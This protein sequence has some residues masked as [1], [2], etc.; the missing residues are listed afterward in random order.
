MCEVNSFPQVRI[1]SWTERQAMPYGKENMVRFILD[2]EGPTVLQEQTLKEDNN[3]NVGT[4][5]Q[6]RANV[7]F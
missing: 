3:L 2:L 1:H 5:I 6:F 4:I 7:S